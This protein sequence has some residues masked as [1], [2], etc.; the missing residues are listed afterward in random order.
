MNWYQSTDWEIL[1]EIGRRMRQVRITKYLT[2]HDLAEHAGLSRGTI[3]DLENGK[4]LN[5]LS[6]IRVLRSLKLLEGFDKLLPEEGPIAAIQ[7][8]RKRVKP[9][10]RK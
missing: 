6:M 2:Q 8:P 5:A 1:A 3:R 9:S 4:P 10:K 7:P